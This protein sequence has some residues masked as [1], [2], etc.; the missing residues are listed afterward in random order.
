MRA[1]S[2]SILPSNCF[3]LVGVIKHVYGPKMPRHE[4]YPDLS[5]ALMRVTEDQRRERWLVGSGRRG[6]L[7]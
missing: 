2:D 5:V 1:K 6:L 3:S 4:S 7:T